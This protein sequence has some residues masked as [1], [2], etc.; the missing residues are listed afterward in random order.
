MNPAIAMGFLA[1]YYLFPAYAE[2][3]WLHRGLS[4]RPIL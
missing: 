3:S 4:Q 1:M 2:Q